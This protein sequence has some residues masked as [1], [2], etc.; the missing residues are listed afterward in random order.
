MHPHKAVGAAPVS[1]TGQVIRIGWLVDEI[2]LSIMT[3]A[4]PQNTISPSVC[5]FSAFAL[6]MREMI[7]VK[8]Y[9]LFFAAADFVRV[10]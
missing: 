9:K 6:P 8:L 10:N 4:A 2:A 7:A 5:R 1:Y 3:P